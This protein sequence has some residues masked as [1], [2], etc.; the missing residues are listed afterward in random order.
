MAH[1]NP[2]TRLWHGVLL[3]VIGIIL[4]GVGLTMGG[5]WNGFHLWPWGNTEK[6]VDIQDLDDDTLTE[7][8]HTKKLDLQEG[9]LPSGIQQFDIDL[10]TANLILKTGANPGYKITAQKNRSIEVGTDDTVFHVKEKNWGGIISSDMD[11]YRQK[12]EITLPKDTKF[13]ACVIKFGA[14]SIH[15]DTMDVNRLQIEN[16]AGSIKGVGI[17]AQDV[18]L[19]TGAGAIVFNDCTFKDVEFKAGAGR[20]AFT[21][22]LNGK[23]VIETGAGSVELHIGGT[24]SDYDITYERG[25]G[26]VIIG[27]ET[28]AGIGNGRAGTSDASRQLKLT[29]G[30]GAIRVVFDH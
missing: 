20:I 14:G 28:F 19:E 11:I 9:D 25:L 26:A 17:Q 12:I 6:W 21:G 3:L 22:E 29:T 23:S 30:V 8:V 15:I 7:A 18:E 24:E 16:G 27:N 4:I 2:G 10:K 13:A 5:Q 1:T